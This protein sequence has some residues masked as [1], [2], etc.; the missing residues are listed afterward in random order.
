[1]IS[2]GYR[3]HCRKSV[4]QFGDTVVI[5][6]AHQLSKACL[7]L[8]DSG[9]DPAIVGRLADASVATGA[10][11]PYSCNEALAE[12][13]RGRFASAVEWAEKTLAQETRWGWITVHTSA[14]LAMAR[15][16]LKQSELAQAALKR[17]QDAA[18][19]L[20]KL[21]SAYPGPGWHDAVICDALLREAKYLIEGPAQVTSE[22]K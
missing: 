1:M 15:H 14:T 7:T 2:R 5:N 10:W 9:V 21:D 13:R 22:T 19:T 4:E 8:P 16:Q 12:Y 6:R 11:G 18:K 17:A 3:E 20:P